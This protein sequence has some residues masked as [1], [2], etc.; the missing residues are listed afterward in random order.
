[1][2]RRLVPWVILLATIATACDRSS[3][4]PPGHLV[5]RA[6]FRTATGIVRTSF[7][8]VADTEAE[9]ER[10]L[11]GRTS[12]AKNGGE[13]FVFD[14][15]VESAFWMK[16]TKIPLAIAFW[17]STGRIVGI[18]EMVPC[19]ADPCPLYR[20]PAPYSYA[21]EMNAGW[22]TRRGVRIGDEVDLQVAT[23]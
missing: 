14:G 13:V 23:E 5:A 22:F 8:D 15:A 10:G 7:L 1:M 12:L 9:R 2:P 19:T 20:S 17:D 18:V 11:M 21:L 16:D 4:A 3:S 6:T